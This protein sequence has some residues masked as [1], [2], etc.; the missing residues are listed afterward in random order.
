M[1]SFHG[2]SVAADFEE[3][4][5]KHMLTVREITFD[6]LLVHQPVYVG[7]ENVSGCDLYFEMVLFGVSQS[8]LSPWTHQSMPAEPVWISPPAPPAIVPPDIPPPARSEGDER[9]ARHLAT[10]RDM[11]DRP[12]KR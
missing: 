2:C 10:L 11:L 5:L 8:S 12:A 4:L 9:R 6:T 1:P 3:R 7:V